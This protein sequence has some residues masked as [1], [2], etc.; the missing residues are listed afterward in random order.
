MSERA[1]NLFD[2]LRNSLAEAVAGVKGADMIPGRPCRRAGGL[3]CFFAHGYAPIAIEDDQGRK[4]NPQP[5][6]TPLPHGTCSEVTTTAL[7]IKHKNA[8]VSTGIA[9]FTWQ[10]AMFEG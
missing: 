7:A 4:D 5:A 9:F 6:D 10:P 8:A 3:T 1:C 2:N